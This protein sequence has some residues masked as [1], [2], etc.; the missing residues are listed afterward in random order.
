[1]SGMMYTITLPGVAITTAQDLIYIKAPTL[2]CTVLHEVV[3]T[4]DLIEVSEQLP[5]EILFRSTDNTG[6]TDTTPT[7]LMGGYAAYTGTTTDVQVTDGTW[8]GEGTG[9]GL[10]WRESQNIL[11]GWHYLPTPEG[12]P[13]LA[14]ADR[15]AIRIDTAPAGS[16]TVS[17]VALIERLGG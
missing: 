9:A 16:T 15:F 8:A 1:M 14:P 5:L 7:P 11:N 6:G 3:V 13:M 4:Q 10:I 12:R 2:V 17:A